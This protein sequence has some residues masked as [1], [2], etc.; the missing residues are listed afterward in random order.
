MIG[1]DLEPVLDDVPGAFPVCA[2]ECTKA[3]TAKPLI[4]PEKAKRRIARIAT[5]RVCW[6][7]LFGW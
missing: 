6:F 7:T 1:V 2:F 4:S 3:P 5:L